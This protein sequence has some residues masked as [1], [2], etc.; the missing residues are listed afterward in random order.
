MADSK[1][2][3]TLEQLNIVKSYIDK[4]DAKSLKSGKYENNTLTLYTTTDESGD[5]TVSI[6]LPEEMFLDQS[7][8]KFVDNFVWSEETYPNSENPNLDGKPVFV[9]AV[10]GDTSVSYSFASLEKLIDVFTGEETNSVAVTV[11]D[12]NKISAN[13]KV[14]ATKGN[15]LIV[16]DD[17]LYVPEVV[18]E[19]ATDEEIN[20]IFAE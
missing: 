2:L 16:N 5:P 11:T 6:S 19:F 4:E 13:V 1:K 20:A 8:T 7:K 14:S 12:D 18:L 17:G 15:A 3:V 9:L 10:K